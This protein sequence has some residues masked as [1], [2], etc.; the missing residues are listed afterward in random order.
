MISSL[1]ATI[2]ALKEWIQEAKEILKEPQEIY[3]AQML[4][5]CHSMRNRMVMTYA[6]GKTKAKRNNLKRFMEECNYLKER[7][8]F[9]LSDF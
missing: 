3:L 7:G 6:R 4:S 1:Q 9:T 5:E 2:A 8:V